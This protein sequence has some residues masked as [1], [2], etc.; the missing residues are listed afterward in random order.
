MV[1][2]PYQVVLRLYYIAS[3]HWPVIDAHYASVDLIRLPAH[4]FLNCV[5]AWCLDRVPP[6]KAEEWIIMLNEPLQ[7]RAKKEPSDMEAQIEGESFMNFMA[8][9]QAN[10]A[11]D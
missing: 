1:W 7:G 4:R 11:G 5:Y 2:P 9:H 3:E 8:Q 6:D 10:M